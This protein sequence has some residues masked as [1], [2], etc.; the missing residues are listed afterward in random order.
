MEV[1]SL[2]KW[3]VFVIVSLIIAWF[4][5]GSLRNRRS[6]GFFR[7]FAFTSV[8]GIILLNIDFWFQNPFAPRQ[9]IS[10]IFLCTSLFLAIHGFWLLRKIGKPDSSITD[11]TR[12]DIEKTTHLVETGAY[13]LIRH[14]LYASLLYFGWG[15]FLKHTSALA[16]LLG[17]ILT[18]AVILTARVEEQE[19]IENFGP[20][21]IDYMKRTKRFLPFL[22]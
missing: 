10:W 9:V 19:N 17:I 5:R 15:A 12:L 6:H 16:G 22:Y 20:E 7:F 1:L 18:V 21:Y 14:P 8:L 4:T 13:R 11:S 3:L 2:W